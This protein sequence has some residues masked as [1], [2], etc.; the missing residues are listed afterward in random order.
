MGWK[1]LIVM[2]KDMF[3]GSFVEYR[4]DFFVIVNIIMERNVMMFIVLEKFK[5][6]VEKR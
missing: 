4:R 3:F 1:N 6:R 5:I 2:F